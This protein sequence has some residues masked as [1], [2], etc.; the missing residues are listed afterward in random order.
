[1]RLTILPG[2]PTAAYIHISRDVRDEL[3]KTASTEL[4]Y[5][6]I[7]PLEREKNKVLSLLYKTVELRATI[8][9]DRLEFLQDTISE[10]AKAS[11]KNI[12]E[13]KPSTLHRDT[14]QCLLFIKAYDEKKL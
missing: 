13:G 12:Q 7:N 9:I 3:F 8:E 1:M 6:R 4:D 10:I 5:D 2:D 11:T 14:M